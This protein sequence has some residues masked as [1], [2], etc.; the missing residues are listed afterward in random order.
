MNPYKTCPPERDATRF[1]NLTSAYE[2]IKDMDSRLHRI[3]Y[4]HKPEGG[5]PLE[6]V[7]DYARQEPPVPPDLNTL[8][9]FLRTLA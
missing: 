9:R 2:S 1:R 7:A 3:V 6:V 4:P 8:K 5:T